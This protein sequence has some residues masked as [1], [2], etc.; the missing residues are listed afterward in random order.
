MQSFY[1]NP[2]FLKL[3]PVQLKHPTSTT[4]VYITN[5]YN[6]VKNYNYN[7]YFLLT[8]EDLWLS[9]FARL[10][11]FSV[12]YIVMDTSSTVLW[13]S[14]CVRNINVKD[15]TLAAFSI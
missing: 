9:Q 8:Y 15:F 11:V 3:F 13:V 7:I 5:L 1:F 6:Y 10:M 14:V 2:L 4:V 12:N